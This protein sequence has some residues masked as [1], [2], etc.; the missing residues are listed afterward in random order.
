MLSLRSGQIGTFYW[1]VQDG[2][3]FWDDRMHEI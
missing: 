2:T 1:N 3:H